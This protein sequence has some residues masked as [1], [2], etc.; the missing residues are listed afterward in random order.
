MNGTTNFM[1]DAIAR[2]AS[3]DA[4][5][6]AAQAR[7]FAEADPSDD[8][9]GR[10]AAAKLALAARVAFG[11]RLSIS[12]V[13]RESIRHVNEADLARGRGVTRHVARIAADDCFGAPEVSLR[14]LP[15]DHFLSQAIDEDNRALITLRDGA[16]IPVAGKGAGRWPTAEAVFADMLSAWRVANRAAPAARRRSVA[17]E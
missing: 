13:K 9:D 6:A 3:Y 12:D 7:G 5:L 15:T 11:R 17:A 8:V 4:A 16:R 14:R 2:G 10:D 1:L